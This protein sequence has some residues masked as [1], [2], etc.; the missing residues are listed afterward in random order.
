MVASFTDIKRE[1]YTKR[2][3]ILS[4]QWAAT[5]SQMAGDL[6]EGRKVLLK[7]KL[8]DYETQIQEVKQEIAALDSLDSENDPVLAGT[9]DHQADQALKE[10]MHE[11]DFADAKEMLHSTILHPIP[12]KRPFAA[13]LLLHDCVNKAG[14]LCLHHIRKELQKSG[15]SFSQYPCQFGYS[16]NTQ[17]FLDKLAN[18]H[19][20]NPD[21]DLDAYA[22]AI[23]TVICKK[24]SR[25]STFFYEINL[26][27]NP[28]I[29]KQFP[30]ELIT[31]FW[32]PLI[33]ALEDVLE[34]KPL[35]RLVFTFSIDPNVETQFLD[36]AY[37]CHD[38]QFQNDKFFRLPL[39][40]W[41][42]KDISAWLMTFDPEKLPD[43]DI[44]QLAQGIYR[45]NEGIPQNIASAILKNETIRNAI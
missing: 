26:Q 9:L 38:T 3:A 16:F 15:R 40:D 7:H 13:F 4:E 41:S 12:D 29:N 24:L 30:Q 25:N 1:Q 18:Y 14:E 39:S 35:A 22:A 8:D 10:K 31:I 43:E 27:H 28:F 34:E 45:T 17:S 44:D 37:F 5:Y 2:M 36:A 21:P 20:V 6:D 19:N 32:Q 42:E 33:T 23:I 11:I